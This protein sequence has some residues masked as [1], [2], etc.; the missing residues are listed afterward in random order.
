MDSGSG[1]LTV[2]AACA[3]ALPDRHF[4]YFGDHARA[5]YGIRGPDEIYRFTIEGVERLFASGCRLVLIACNTAA[6]VGLRRLQQEW[7]ATHYPDRRVLGVHVPLIE[8]LTGTQWAYP[9]P[10]RPQPPR[11]IAV[12]A[13]PTTV[14][15]GGFEREVSQRCPHITVIGQACA[16]LA[17]AIEA[18]ADDAAVANIIEGLWAELCARPGAAAIDSAV[19]ACTHYPLVADV[20]RAVLPARV[21][22]L[23]QPAIVAGTLIGYLARNPHLSQRRSAGRIELTTSGD[24][25]L[26]A[27]TAW[28]PEAY[29]HFTAVS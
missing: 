14:A 4:L 21:Q 11:T 24:P 7:L 29:R 23:T 20:F 12:F 27:R 19:L 13:T 15:S 9:S 18:G 16:G 5:P 25:A 8:A 1:G 2:L 26:I 3:A 22:V 28:L 10:P 17:D 6:A